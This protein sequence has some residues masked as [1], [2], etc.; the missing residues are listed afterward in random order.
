MR[1]E[2]RSGTSAGKL[3]QAHSAS[4]HAVPIEAAIKNHAGKYASFDYD[5]TPPPQNATDLLFVD[6]A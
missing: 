1:P 4:P 2:I 3:P 5:Y 6:D